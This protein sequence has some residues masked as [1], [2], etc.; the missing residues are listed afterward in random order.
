MLSL[1][2]KELSY[3]FNNPVG[4]IVAILFAIFANFL[5]IKDLFLR[6]DSSMRPFFDILPWLFLV[7]I[8]ALTMRIFAEEKRVNT[9]EVLLTLPLSETTIVVAK[10]AALLI[11]SIFTLLLTLLI[12]VTLML[13]GKPY[14]PEIGV[15]YCG[16]FLLSAAFISVAIFFSSLTKNQI[17]AFL[18]SVLTIFL[19]IVMGGD[20]LASFVPRFI[21]ENLSSFSPLYHYSNFLKGL[22]DLRSVVYFVS[23]TTLFIFL[24]VINLEKRE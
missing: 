16:A 17:V 10:L 6:G 5:F 18:C 7:F 13:V 1:F 20:F 15:A 12:P 2:K 4:Y 14:S 11:F 21:Q 22:V 23:L 3:Y 8:P 9:I 24:T 19:L